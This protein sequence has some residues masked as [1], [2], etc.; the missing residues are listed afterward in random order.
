MD[1]NERVNLL[2]EGVGYYKPVKVDYS[3]S[4]LQPFTSKET[5]EVHYNKHYKGYVN[6]CN[7]LIKRPKPLVE[8]AQDIKKYDDKIRFNVGGALNHSIWFR[9]L[10]KSV[11]L[12]GS[13][14]DLIESNFKSYDKFKEQFEEKALSIMG[15]GWCWLTTK[16]EL[17]TTPNQDNPLMHRSMGDPVLGLDMWEH[18]FYLDYQSDKKKYVKN[19]FKCINWDAINEVL[20]AK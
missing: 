8:M 20:E 16:G 15:S 12:N 7:E 17:H 13:V 9:T 3:F 4:S 1:F 10:K 5:M 14:K 11:T 2:I 6:K 18:S 19:F